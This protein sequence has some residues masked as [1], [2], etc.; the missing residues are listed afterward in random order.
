[1]AVMAVIDGGADVSDEKREVKIDVR[2]DAWKIARAVASNTER[3]LYDGPPGTGKTYAAQRFGLTDGQRVFNITC[4]EEMPAA[5]IRG[6]FV[7]HGDRFVWMDGPGVAAMRCGGRLVI[8]EIEKASGDVQTFLLAI[9]DDVESRA[10]TL[11]TGETVVSA[12]GYTIAAT[13]NGDADID[14]NPAL[15]DRFTVR[16]RIHDVHPD[17]V[18]RLP[19]DLQKAARDTGAIEDPDRR[20]SIRSWLEFARLRVVVDEPMAAA[21]VFGTRASDILNSLR[22]ARAS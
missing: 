8:N 7:P 9:L 5:E 18:K 19:N 14:L 12:P 15:R 4:T 13:M 11:P 6:H 17:A 3:I 22:I 20:I 1:M 10:L 2:K 16:I 21:A